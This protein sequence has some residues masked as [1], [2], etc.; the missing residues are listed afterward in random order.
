MNVKSGIFIG[1]IF[2]AFIMGFVALKQAMPEAKEDRIFKL[3]I[4][5]LYQFNTRP[6]GLS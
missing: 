5:S 2:A 3:C 4:E 1:V 6:F